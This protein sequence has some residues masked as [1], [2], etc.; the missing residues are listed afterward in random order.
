MMTESA[1]VRC[2]IRSRDVSAIPPSPPVVVRGLIRRLA[3]QALLPLGP[4]RWSLLT[5]TVAQLAVSPGPGDFWRHSLA[6]QPP[7]LLSHRGPLSHAAQQHHA[8]VL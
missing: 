6:L 1:M 2:E 7:I 8:A 5:A 3:R 4:R